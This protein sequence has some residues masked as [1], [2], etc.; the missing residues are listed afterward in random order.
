[1]AAADP[2][3]SC[4]ALTSSLTPLFYRRRHVAPQ[5]FLRHAQHA[6]TPLRQ[7]F[8]LAST[9]DKASVV[10]AAAAAVSILCD[11]PAPSLVD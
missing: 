8:F 2:T 10:P 1:M 6:S 7:R 5:D 3:C 4:P 9:F 11:W